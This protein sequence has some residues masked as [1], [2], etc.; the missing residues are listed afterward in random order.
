MRYPT[1]S[2]AARPGRGRRIRS[3]SVL[4]RKGAFFFR[5]RPAC[6]IAAAGSI[7]RHL[8][9]WTVLRRCFWRSWRRAPSSASYRM[10]PE[11]NIW[12]IS[13]AGGQYDAGLSGQS[14]FDP[15]EQ[16]ASFSDCSGGS[17][18]RDT[19]VFPFGETTFRYRYRLT[20]TSR[21]TGLSS[22]S[23]VE[24]YVSS[25]R[26]SVYCPLEVV[27][28]E[29]GTVTA[30]LRGADPLSFRMDYDEEAAS[31]LWE[32]EGLWG[33]STDPLAATDCLSLVYGACGQC[34]QGIPLH[35]EHDDDGVGDSPDGEKKSDGEG[36]RKQGG[37][38]SRRGRCGAG[39]PRGA[40]LPSHAMIPRT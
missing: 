11:R 17:V 12:S 7:V 37:C 1:N 26:P 2:A 28:E 15:R 3:G 27:V 13:G 20:A 5:K 39:E 36:Y 6:R 16:S 35:R 34:R 21:A 22:F 23:E 14:P 32:W 40:P 10:P 9:T 18:V 24:V 33:T 4:R 19:G 25:R 38:A 30:R 31:V 29:G 8:R